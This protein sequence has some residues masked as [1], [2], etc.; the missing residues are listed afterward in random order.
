MLYYKGLTEPISLLLPL[1]CH[2]DFTLLVKGHLELLLIPC[3]C[4]QV[5]YFISKPQ[6][7]QGTANTLQRQSLV[8]SCWFAIGHLHTQCWYLYVV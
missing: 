7:T 8:H 2:S 3:H 6:L 5:T 1:Q 4:Y